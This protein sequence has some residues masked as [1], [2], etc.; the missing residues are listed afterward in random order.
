MPGDVDFD[1]LDDA[2]CILTEAYDPDDLLDG[3]WVSCHLLRW[4]NDFVAP[5]TRG[6]AHDE[7]EDA[8]TLAGRS[9]GVGAGF[10]PPST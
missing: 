5:G 4:R 3:S 7:L 8:L 6:S 2:D 1:L 10:R 9:V